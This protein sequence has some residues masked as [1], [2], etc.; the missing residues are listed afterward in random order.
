[1]LA[2]DTI[3]NFL[4]TQIE[5]ACLQMDTKRSVSIYSVFLS[6]NFRKAMQ[7]PGEAYMCNQRRGIPNI[8]N[9]NIL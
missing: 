2:E 4:I 8:W 6:S 7:W 3:E 9:P 5:V 1:M